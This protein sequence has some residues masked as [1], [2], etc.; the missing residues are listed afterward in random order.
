MPSIGNYFNEV[1]SVIFRSSMFA[2]GMMHSVEE[3]NEAEH[4]T[5]G[6]EKYYL[7]HGQKS[8]KGNGVDVKSKKKQ[9]DIKEG[10]QANRRRGGR[11]R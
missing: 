7:K 1:E 9:Q 8:G 4:G 5:D 2:E 11:G 10:V 3:N 6:D